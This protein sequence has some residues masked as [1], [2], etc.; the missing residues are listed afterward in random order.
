MT[1]QPIVQLQNLSKTIGG[2]QL[3]QQLN[4]D[5]LKVKRGTVNIKG[6]C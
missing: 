6:G 4:I 1:S 5:L 2:Q 3:I